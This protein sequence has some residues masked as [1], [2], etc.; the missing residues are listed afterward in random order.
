MGDSRDWTGCRLGQYFLDRRY[1]DFDESDGQLYAARHADTGRPALVLV[2]EAQGTWTPRG[3]WSVRVVSQSTP[4][5]LATELECPPPASA[6]ALSDMN[7]GFIRLAG[8]VASVEDQREANEAFTQAPSLRGLQGWRYLRTGALVAGALLLVLLVL[9]P[10]V[11]A[12]STGE[13]LLSESPRTQPTVWTDQAERGAV[14]GYPMP[15]VAYPEQ[16]KPPCGTGGYVE[17]RGG[18]WAELRQEPPCG[19]FAEHEGKCYVPVRAKKPERR[20]VTP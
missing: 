9:W 1:P 13:P 8:A 5:F 17:V 14:V 16:M 19:D 12:P 20:S 6:R 7:L 4:P 11:L 15:P 10:R 2:P 18:C 3:D